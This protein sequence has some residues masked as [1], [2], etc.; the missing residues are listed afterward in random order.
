MALPISVTYTFATA[1][2]AIPLSQL[3][4]NFTTVVN[5]INGIG[6]GTNALSNATING[7]TGN[8]AVINVGSGQFYKDTSGNIGIGVSDPATY[9]SLAV[10]AGATANTRSVIITANS[11]SYNGQLSY[12]RL[13]TTVWN[14]GVDQADSNKFKIANSATYD[15]ASGTAMT[16]DGS[17]NVGIGTASPSAVLHL[18]R[19]GSTD[20][21]TYYQNG[22]GGLFLVGTNGSTGEAFLYNGA[23]KATVFHTNGIERMRIDSSG[24]FLVGTT[25]SSF[26]AGVGH[27]LVPS[28]TAPIISTVGTATTDAS[29]TW[30]LYS[31]GAGAYRFYVGYGGTVFAT[32]TTISSLSDQRLK[33]N[34]RDLDIGLDAIMALKP[35]KFDWK[36]GKGKNIKNDRGF[37]AQEFEQVFPDLIDTWKDPAPE[38]EEPYKSVRQDLIP[39]LVKAIQELTDRV[40]VLEG[41]K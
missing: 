6:N 13:G 29:A 30:A 26:T 19:A 7:F 8:T 22:N 1:T 24:N 12:L 20:V 16:I 31:T 11:N 21:Y 9:G 38:G 34:V 39:V 27:K 15:L 28:A 33:E 10:Y 4:A 17:L 37:V 2:S 5:G 40:A 23:N 25:N 36:E 3:D 14:V 18:N 35:R 41:K 32:N